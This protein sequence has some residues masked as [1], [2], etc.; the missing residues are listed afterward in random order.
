M[1]ALEEAR[2]HFEAGDLEASIS[3]LQQARACHP[4]DAVVA[5]TLG[6]VLRQAGRGEEAL[7]VFREAVELVPNEPAAWQALGSAQRAK[8]NAAAAVASLQRAVALAPSAVSLLN[9]LGLAQMDRGEL[10]AARRHF[11]RCV[12]EDPTYLLAWHNL[13][14]VALRSG[15]L[16][17]AVEACRRVL[18]A[19]PDDGKA[20]LR[21]ASALRRQRLLDEAAAVLETVTSRDGAWSFERG[22]LARAQGDPETAEAAFGRAAEDGVPGARRAWVEQLRRRAALGEAEAAARAGI[23]KGDETLWAVLANTLK[24]QGRAG[25]ARVAFERALDDGDD[26]TWSAALLNLNYLNGVDVTP[27]QCASAHRRYGARLAAPR[28]KPTRRPS[29]GL[30][31]GYLSSDIRDHA[32]SRFLEP[33]LAHHEVETVGFV[34]VARPDATTIRLEGHFDRSHRVGELED[35]AL[36][37]AIEAAELDLLVELNGHT[38]RRLPALARRLAPVQLSYLGYPHDTGLPGIDARI[39]DAHTDPNADPRC[40]HVETCF[41]AFRPDPQAPEVTLRGD[42]PVVFGSFNNQAKLRPAWLETWGRIV[43]GVTGARLLLKNPSLDDAVTRDRT[44]ARLRAGGLSADRIEFVGFLSDPADHLGLYAQVDVALDTFPYHGTTTTCEALWMG[45]PVVTCAGPVHAARVG[46]SLLHQV[47][48]EGLV[49]EDEESFVEVAQGLAR[50]VTRRI[51][52]RGTLRPTMRDS[53][54]CDGARMA[55]SLER[56]YRAQVD[57]LR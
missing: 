20:T 10:A 44:L 55:R 36:A 22:A 23:S 54:L 29:D 52:L 18:E 13:G 7:H 9:S 31:V 47:G 40:L 30:R 51:E 41:L 12:E 14:E 38:G 4:Q 19:A 33:I 48:L 16:G 6:S 8:G 25:E 24:L 49:T 37:A 21:L 32:V 27:E 57:A 35:G 56:V 2:R 3:C 53:P 45:V 1:D 11:E 42:A 15:A 43:A 17:V 5:L 28:D 34:D 46:C 39:A 50:D 26:E